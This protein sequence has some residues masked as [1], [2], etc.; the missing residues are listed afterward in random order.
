MANGITEIIEEV[1]TQLEIIE[2]ESGQIEVTTPPINS[3][4]ISFS[5]SAVSSDLDITT[6]TEVITIDSVSEDTTVNISETSPT[7]VEVTSETTIIDITERLILSGSSELHFA[8][9]IQ[10]PFSLGTDGKIGRGEPK[11]QFDLHISGNL[12]SDIISSSKTQTNQLILEGEGDVNILTVTSGSNTPVAINPSGV[13]VMDNYQYTP[14]PVEGGL[15]Y[16]GSE[17][18]LGTVDS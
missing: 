13:V 11:P 14:P 7:S 17:F 10:N 16:S 1:T 4:E 9:L 15:L 12:F 5:G 18:Y 6:S 8:K 2:S 3:I